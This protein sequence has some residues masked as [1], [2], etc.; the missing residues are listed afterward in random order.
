MI[1]VESDFKLVYNATKTTSRSQL[2]H[3]TEIDESEE[4]FYGGLL[5]SEWS[6]TRRW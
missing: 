2:D 4:T 3:V 1:T 5:P 6:A